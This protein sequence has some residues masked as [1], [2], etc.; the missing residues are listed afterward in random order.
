MLVRAFVVEAGF[1]RRGDNDPVAG[2]ID[3]V[4]V[5]LI[6]G[7]HL[8][9]GVG[10][11]EWIFGTFAFDGDDVAV[12]AVEVAEDGVGELAVDFDMFFDGDREA[13]AAA[14]RAGVAEEGFEEVVKE[15]RQDLRFTEVVQ[16]LGADELG[17]VF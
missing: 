1:A 9:A 11:I 15:A 5:A 6:D 14:G 10:A 16:P 4:T 3:R 17:P 7:R 12:L 13:R 2:K 8:A